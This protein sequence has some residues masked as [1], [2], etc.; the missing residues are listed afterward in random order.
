MVN[1]KKAELMCTTALYEKTRGREP[2]RIRRRYNESFAGGTLAIVLPAV[3]AYSL[4]VFLVSAAVTGGDF[5]LPQGLASL[6]IMLV[7]FMFIG[8]VFVVAYYRAS[9]Y[10]LTRRYED[11]RCSIRKYELCIEKIEALDAA[12]GGAEDEDSI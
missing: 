3:V 5:D 8:V 1:A 2:L 12:S 7:C 10:M 9:S 4:I 6:V 11:I